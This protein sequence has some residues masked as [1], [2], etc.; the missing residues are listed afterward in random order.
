M[1]FPAI[2]R[3]GEKTLNE[4]SALHS[5][6]WVDGT[7]LSTAIPEIN[8]AQVAKWLEDNAQALKDNSAEN[9]TFLE[10][11]GIPHKVFVAPMDSHPAFPGLTK[12]ACMIGLMH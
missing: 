10:L 5:G 4:V 7:L 9:Q 3:R 8:Q 1:G 11:K 2:N 6:V 12:W